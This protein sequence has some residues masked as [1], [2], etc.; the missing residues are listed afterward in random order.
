MSTLLLIL[1]VVLS[2]LAGIWVIE[3]VRA[4]NDF[5]RIIGILGFGYA[6]F[7]VLSW[8]L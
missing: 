3:Q 7:T 4:G 5:W 1:F 8:L 2:V 6:V